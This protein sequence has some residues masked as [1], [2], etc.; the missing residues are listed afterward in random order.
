LLYTCISDSALAD[1]AV[2]EGML[3]NKS[4]A[5]FKFS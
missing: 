3:F 2:P 5:Y 4:I 1:T